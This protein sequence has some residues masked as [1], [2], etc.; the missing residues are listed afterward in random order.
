M[1]QEKQV[2]R[3]TFGLSTERRVRGLVLHDDKGPLD[4]LEV[5]LQTRAEFG[6]M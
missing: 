2:Q 1:D 4:G 6:G 5:E 3:T